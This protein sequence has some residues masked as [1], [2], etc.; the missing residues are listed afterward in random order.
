MSPPEPVLTAR[1]HRRLADALIAAAATGRTL[2]PLTKWYPELTAADA[3]RIRD[4]VLERRLAQ[5]ER[6]IGAKVSLGETATGRGERVGEPRFAW[7]TDGM[8]LRDGAVDVSRLA[9]PR[10]EAKLGFRLVRSLRG[11]P[12]TA[13]EVLAA[14]ESVVPCL[15]ILD[16]RFDDEPRGLADDV[17]E[18]GATA[19]LVLGAGAPPPADGH[20]MR[21]RVLLRVDGSDPEVLPPPVSQRARVP[22]LEA[23]SWLGGRLA[24]KSMV[25]GPGTL[26]VSPPIGTPIALAPG[27]SLKAH[28]SSLGT[29][30]LDAIAG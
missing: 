5:G 28:F 26:L 1:Q 27:L 9:R 12:P 13:G 21:L 15:D 17:A 11:S 16:S 22:A 6:V 24:E 3:S 4:M 10:V 29:V 25:P 19:R 7:L 23:L 14:T 2:A 18:N 30:Q 20:L 8:L